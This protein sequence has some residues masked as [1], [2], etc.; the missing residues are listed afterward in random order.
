MQNLTHAAN[1]SESF[2]LETIMNACRANP[3]RETRIFKGRA[4][5]FTLLADGTHEACL[6]DR[7]NVVVALA[8]VDE[9]DV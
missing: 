4:V 9:Y 6:R 5:S 1:I 8:N 2:A 3:A 7:G